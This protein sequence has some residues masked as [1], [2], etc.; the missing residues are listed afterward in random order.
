M[1]EGREVRK[2]RSRRQT[3]TNTDGHRVESSL[4]CVTG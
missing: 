1:E 4:C 2:K 3:Q